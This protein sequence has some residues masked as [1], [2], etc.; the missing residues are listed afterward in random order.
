[1]VVLVVDS[2]FSGQL[3][4]AAREVLNKHQE[5]G[6]GGIILMVSSTAGQMSWC[7]AST[8]RW[9]APWTRAWRATPTMTAT[10]R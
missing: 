8:R 6:K 10:Q 9:P 4:Y 3:R 2:C 1:M 5:P 7:W